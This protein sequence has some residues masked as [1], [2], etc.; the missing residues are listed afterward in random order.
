M[1]AVLVEDWTAF[2]GKQKN[3]VIE[4][5]LGLFGYDRTMPKSQGKG[6]VHLVD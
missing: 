4:R 3:G 6:D 5:L 1:I 2:V